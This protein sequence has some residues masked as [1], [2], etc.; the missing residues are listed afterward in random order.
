M[1]KSVSDAYLAQA[2]S[3][4]L[5]SNNVT[6]TQL[7]SLMS[8]ITEHRIDY[9]DLYIQKIRSESW[10]MENGVVKFG[11]FTADQGFGL[12]AI[13]TDHTAFA[14]SQHI[15]LQSLK[16]AARSVKSVAAPGRKMITV[17]PGTQPFPG[18]FSADDPVTGRDSQQKIAL[19]EKVYRLVCAMD[20]HVVQ[21]T[22]NIELSFSVNY[23]LRH[24]LYESADIRPML[25]LRVSVVVEKN[26]R[27]ERASTGLGG[28]GDF[29]LFDDN[30]LIPALRKMVDTA[31]I[32]LNAID[33]PSGMMPV[34]IASGWPGML[35]HEAMGH[36][37]EGDFNRLGTSVYSGRVGERIAPPGV[38]I[39]DD[40]T[41]HN[42]RGSI[43]IDDEGTPSQC[44]TLIEDGILQ[45]YMHDTLSARLMKV[46]PTGNGRRQSY[47]HLPMP[48][49]TNTFMRN[50]SYDPEEI[51]A[52]VDKGIYLEDLG[53]GQVD[54]VSGQYSFQTALAYLIEDGKLTSPIKD[55][56]LTGNG[57][58]TLQKISM[59]GNNLALDNGNAV[60]GKAGQSVPVCVGQPTLKVDSL[61]VGGTG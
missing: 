28:R 34:V 59:V 30:Q 13:E 49:M 27:R 11:S 54:I 38:T 37:L 12:R 56:T 61:L 20:T 40:G 6:S 16:N 48:R 7:Y 23:I 31:M 41:L 52:S 1:L 55:A 47:A 39:V 36:G 17:S 25:V 32:N 57:P 3:L 44:T 5:D 60:C 51:I 35:L 15:D 14:L 42:Q 21:V 45:G 58:D 22:A 18:R 50:G 19:L 4:L 10:S 2:K 46:P 53:G 33:A 26:G 43:T 24:D 8:E 9:A 29:S